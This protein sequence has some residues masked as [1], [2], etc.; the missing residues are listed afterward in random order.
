L[1]DTNIDVEEEKAINIFK[2]L[3]SVYSVGKFELPV[4]PPNAKVKDFSK[5]LEIFSSKGL[6]SISFNLVIGSVTKKLTYRFQVTTDDV[7]DFNWITPTNVFASVED[8][9]SLVTKYNKLITDGVNSANEYIGVFNEYFSKE[10]PPI[11]TV[12][13]VVGAKPLNIVETTL[14]EDLFVSLSL[15]VVAQGI[16]KIIRIN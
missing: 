5:E 8:H 11:S 3:Q 15:N 4:L 16:S 9:N 6:A 1:S 10:I 7:V 13:R 14:S 12:Y 2:A